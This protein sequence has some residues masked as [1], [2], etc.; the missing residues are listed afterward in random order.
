MDKFREKKQRREEELTQVETLTNGPDDE[1]QLKQ[2]R[3]VQLTEESQQA[4][5]T[6]RTL[7]AEL[8][9]AQVC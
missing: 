2:E 4:A 8:K 1:Q 5:H 3:L 7:E 6:K 9:R